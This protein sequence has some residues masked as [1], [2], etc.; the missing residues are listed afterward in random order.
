[1]SRPSERLAILAADQRAAAPEYQRAKQ[2]LADEAAFTELRLSV[3]HRVKTLVQRGGRNADQVLG[4]VQEALAPI[5]DLAATVAAYEQRREE[6]RKTRA[7]LEETG[8][9]DAE[10]DLLQV[11][12]DL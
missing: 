8:N 4:A 12:A 5:D 7:E 10:F 2:V 1:M 6:I 3:L 9:R 11:G